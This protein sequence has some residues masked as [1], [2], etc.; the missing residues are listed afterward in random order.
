MKLK[1]NV[2]WGVAKKHARCSETLIVNSPQSGGGIND[3]VGQ[4]NQTPSPAKGLQPMRAR[5]GRLEV[6][7]AVL[8]VTVSTIVLAD[9]RWLALSCI[10]Q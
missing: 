2:V 9:L 4:K 6:D 10:V 1:H 5:L 3:T 7:A 8:Q